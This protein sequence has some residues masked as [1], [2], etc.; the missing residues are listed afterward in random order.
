MSRLA[1]RFSD[2]THHSGGHTADTCRCVND[3]TIPWRPRTPGRGSARPMRL[4]WGHLQPSAGR[5][6]CTVRARKPERTSR[7]MNR[8]RRL[9][10]T[11]VPLIPLRNL[12][13]A[14]RGI[15]ADWTSQSVPFTHPIR[16]SIQAVGEATAHDRTSPLAH[17]EG[18]LINGRH[19]VTVP[20]RQ[21][22]GSSACLCPPLLSATDALTVTSQRDR[23]VSQASTTS[24]TETSAT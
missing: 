21:S 20:F 9:Q 8:D 15:C 10:V 16:I 3:D 5:K 23:T 7:H 2:K 13:Y 1:A 12:E 14:E 11:R 4:V 19:T 18:E 6:R 24:R 22:A 17:P